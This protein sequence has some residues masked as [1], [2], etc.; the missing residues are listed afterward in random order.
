LQKK[1][2]LVSLVGM[3]LFVFIYFL[4]AL[5]II[6]DVTSYSSFMIAGM[7]R[8]WSCMYLCVRE[9]ELSNFV[10]AGDQV[11]AGHDPG[12]QTRQ[13]VRQHRVLRGDDQLE[14]PVDEERQLRAVRGEQVLQDEFQLLA[15]M[16]YCPTPFFNLMLQL[17]VREH[18]SRIPSVSAWKEHSASL[19]L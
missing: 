3:P 12:V 15:M 14:G 18:R 13:L 1:L 10:F 19:T 17:N 4:S 6:D 2:A 9:D 8:T 16:T 7:V 11:G 5:N